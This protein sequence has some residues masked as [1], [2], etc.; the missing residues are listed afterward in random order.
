MSL[1][2]DAELI[3]IVVALLVGLAGVLAAGHAVLHKRHSRAAFGWIALCLLFPAFGPVFYL[4]FGINRVRRRASRLWPPHLPAERAT[5]TPVAPP[6]GMEALARL[7]AAVTD[8]P[9]LG[10]NSVQ[11]LHNGE[12]AYPAMLAA[13]DAARERVFLSTYLFDS[14]ATGKAFAAALGRA[15]ARGVDVRVLL[16]GAGELYSFPRARW[17]LRRQG[18]PVARFLPP[19]LLPP[20]FIVNL[21]NHRKI[22]L[23]DDDVVFTGG[24]NIGDRYLAARLDNR[25]RVVDVHFRLEGPIAAQVCAVFRHDWEFATRTAPLAPVELPV[26]RPG[27]GNALCRVVADGPD[28]DLD[29]LVALLIG[30]IGLAA[31]RVAI[32]TPYFLPPRELLGAL[33]AAALRGVDVA[34]LLPGQNNLPYVHRA[35][36]HGLW[37]YLKRGVRV[38][39][40]PPP[41]VHSKLLLID[42]DY[43]QIGSANLDER[44]LRLNFEL[45]VEVYDRA[46]VSELGAHIEAV[47][48]TSREVTL[49]EVDGRPL[50]RRLA[51]GIAWLFSPYL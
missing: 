1:A 47:R 25:R 28:E 14:D 9:L 43:A 18:V 5:L 17:L 8:A 12:V 48:A 40:Q 10:G 24:I 35:T 27:A 42:D 22:L 33:Q 51:D 39:Y 20:A 34:V 23:V 37:E 50:L 45:V 38:Y 15:V 31:R 16:D 13:I 29:R 7:G 49:A 3:G 46:L 19:R 30:G 32:M 41:F 2:A 4:L 44:S 26:P 11:V 6:P 36:R 21:R